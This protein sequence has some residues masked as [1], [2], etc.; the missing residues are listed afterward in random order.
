MAADD[1]NHTEAAKQRLREAVNQLIQAEGLS[2]KDVLDE[3]RQL[4][5]TEEL[6]SPPPRLARGRRRK[7]TP[8][9]EEVWY[10]QMGD[11]TLQMDASMRSDFEAFM[12]N[13][14][15]V[16]SKALPP[17]DENEVRIP[18]DDQ[19]KLPRCVERLELTSSA[20]YYALGRCTLAGR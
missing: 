10:V 17:P 12:R 2:G 15:W 1:A 19:S 5:G 20:F 18:T 11:Q 6:P 14:K 4:V 16:A 9:S 7:K 13:Q 8:G 3:V